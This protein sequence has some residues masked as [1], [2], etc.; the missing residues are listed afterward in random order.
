[1]APDLDR[2][3]LGVRRAGG[4]DDVHHHVRVRQF[5]E[6]LVAEALPLV[7]ARDE[8]GHVEQFDRDVPFPVAAVLRA[9]ALLAVET[10]AAR[11]HV[12]HPAVGV[13]GRERVV[14]DVDVGLRGGGVEGGLAGVRLARERDRDHAGAS[15]RREKRLSVGRGEA[16]DGGHCGSA[17][18]GRGRARLEEAAGD[19]P[20]NQQRL[21]QLR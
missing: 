17:S 5:V 6:E 16:T 8:P 4:V 12:G 3:P 11:P 13:D 10:R 9:A 20:R 7:C 1:M 2:L 15:R 18:G 19:A 14:R 21:A